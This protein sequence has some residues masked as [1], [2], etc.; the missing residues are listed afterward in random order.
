VS[1]GVEAEVR[2]YFPGVPVVLTPNGVDIERFRPD[3]EIRADLRDQ[4]GVEADEI[5]ALFVGGD[6]DRKGLAIAIEGFADAQRLTSR[7]L[8]LWVVGR[9]DERRFGSLADRFG[10][11]DRVVFMGAQTV[12]ERFY[13]AADLFVL[14]TLYETFSL[15]AH[16]AAAA[17]IPVISTRVSGV[18]DLLAGGAAGLIVERSAFGVGAALVRLADDDALR[19]RLGMEGRAHASS[20]TWERSIDSV[21]SVYD[22]ILSHSHSQVAK[23]WHGPLV[24]AGDR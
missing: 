19:R 16:E 24:E 2:R 14:P 21:T 3:S 5:V 23:T 17:G 20:V 1:R 13:Q 6:W 9:G 11:A 7:R 10:V 22:A 18:E 4:H 12:A 8:L 15:A